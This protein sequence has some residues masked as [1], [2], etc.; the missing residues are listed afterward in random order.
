MSDLATCLA[1][2]LGRKVEQL[3]HKQIL[4][5]KKC[6]LFLCPLF[7]RYSVR[8]LSSLDARQSNMETRLAICSFQ[9]TKL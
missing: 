4:V 2:W 3:I 6:F 9:K 5:E 1:V 7:H 8:R